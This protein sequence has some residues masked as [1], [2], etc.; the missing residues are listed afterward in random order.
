VSSPCLPTAQAFLPETALTLKREVAYVGVRPWFGLT[1]DDEQDPLV[2]AIRR[3]AVAMRP[4][5]RVH[6]RDFLLGPADKGVPCG[7]GSVR[8]TQHP[9]STAPVGLLTCE[10][11]QSEPHD[12]SETRHEDATP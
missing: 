4:V 1:R 11:R 7:A 9:T 12:E 5:R 8:V 6:V 10:R 2:T 3:Q